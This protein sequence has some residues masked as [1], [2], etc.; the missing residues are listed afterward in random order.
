MTLT[1]QHVTIDCADPRGLAQFWAAALDSSIK[2]DFEEFV[3]VDATPAGFAQLG[4]QRVPE[5]KSAKTRIHL[6]FRVA[7]R[8]AEVERLVALGARAI[9]E[10]SVPGV[11]WTVL[12]D[13]EGNEFCVAGRA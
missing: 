6:D 2:D 13:P 11:K 8:A 3:T 1:L 5:P 10:E 9:G 12:Q 4:F 7:D